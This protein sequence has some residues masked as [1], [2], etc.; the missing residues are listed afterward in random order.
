MATNDEILDAIIED[1][2]RMATTRVIQFAEDSHPSE[3]TSKDIDQLI[4]SIRRLAVR[5][6]EDFGFEGEEPRLEALEYELL[7]TIEGRIKSWAREIERD[8]RQSRA[9]AA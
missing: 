5:M 6:V 8:R 2:W 7:K 9:A 4:D 1:R 3:T